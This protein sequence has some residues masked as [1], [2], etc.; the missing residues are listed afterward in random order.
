L[1]VR[2]CIMFASVTESECC[3][4]GDFAK[5]SGQSPEEC[6]NG[7]VPITQGPTLESL[8]ANMEQMQMQVSK[9][10]A[11]VEKIQSR[12]D[13]P[14]PQPQQQDTGPSK[15]IHDIQ[16]ELSVQ[17][18]AIS[19]MRR[20]FPEHSAQ[21][22]S[23]RRDLHEIRCKPDGQASRAPP[24]VSFRVDDIRNLT[25]LVDMLH[26][27]VNK[28]CEQAQPRDAVKSSDFEELVSSV[29]QLRT[30]ATE[31]WEKLEALK[32]NEILSKLP[33]GDLDFLAYQVLEVLRERRPRETE[34]LAAR[35]GCRSE[36]APYSAGAVMSGSG[37]QK[38]RDTMDE[39]LKSC[40]KFAA[41]PARPCPE[42]PGR[43]RRKK[44]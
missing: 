44:D 24:S 38:I 43:S 31:H 13:Q 40:T 9:L 18:S 12:I 21:L 23:L 3:F 19:D 42:V 25:S 17:R 35:V 1:A 6:L 20:Q 16:M 14:Q 33:Q 32:P 10:E 2:S 30:E 11:L 22:S 41:T 8:A 15:A 36:A 5:E 28:V 37:L 39:V 4:R 27:K 34:L 26:D 29:D 7:E